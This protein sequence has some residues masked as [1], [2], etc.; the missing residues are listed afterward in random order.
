MVDAVE[1]VELE[2]LVVDAVELVVD[3]DPNQR[4]SSSKRRRSS[5]KY[6]GPVSGASVVVVEDVEENVL[7]V[8][9]V[10]LVEEELEL[11]VVD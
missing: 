2:E 7:V 8:D 4:V 6:K 10:E 11:V 3:E 9:A 5:S 1:L